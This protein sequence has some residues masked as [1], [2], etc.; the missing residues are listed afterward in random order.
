MA[1]LTKENDMYDPRFIAFAQY[2][3]SRTAQTD[4]TGVTA[5]HMAANGFLPGVLDAA[6]N[7]QPTITVCDGASPGYHPG[8]VVTG[9]SQSWVSAPLELAAQALR[10]R[11]FDGL[12]ISVRH[13]G[14]NCSLADVA[15]AV[16]SWGG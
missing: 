10:W 9:A 13:Y 6:G 12:D 3:S 15:S 8:Y 2:L 7:F 14:P 5:R 11:N 1:D 16:A 4:S